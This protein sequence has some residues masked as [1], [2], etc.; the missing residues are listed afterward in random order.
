VSISLKASRQA[1]RYPVPTGRWA[2]PGTRRAQNRRRTARVCTPRPF[3]PHQPSSTPGGRLP[4]RPKARWR[5]REVSPVRRS[6]AALS[7]RFKAT[8]E[9]LRFGRCAGL[10]TLLAVSIVQSFYQ[11]QTGQTTPWIWARALCEALLWQMDG[12]S[13]DWAKE[14]AER[15]ADQHVPAITQ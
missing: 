3:Y 1:L 7:A 6:S 13:L 12:Y 9:S 15:L 2:A 11:V 10:F 8:Y 4:T 5:S 14:R